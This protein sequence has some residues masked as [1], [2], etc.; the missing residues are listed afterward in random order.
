MRAAVLTCHV[1]LLLGIATLTLGVAVPAGV[2][3]ALLG[4]A[5]APLA[6]A[7]PGLWAARRYTHQWLAV[8]LVA[9]IGAAIVEVV[10]TAT[11]SAAVTLLAALVELALLLSFIRRGEASR[12]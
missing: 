9:Y 2:S 1:V 5:I 8:L 4:A 7:L 10:A 11:P 3:L 6:L 12:E